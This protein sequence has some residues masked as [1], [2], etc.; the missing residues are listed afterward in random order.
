MSASMMPTSDDAGAGRSRVAR[1]AAA[2]DRGRN[3]NPVR[4]F[5]LIRNG[6]YLLED[7]TAPTYLETHPEWPA[8]AD[9]RRKPLPRQN[10]FHHAGKST[11]GR[12]RHLLRV[13]LPARN[14]MATDD[15]RAGHRAGR[16]H[17]NDRHRPYIRCRRHRGP[18]LDVLGSAE[19]RGV[20]T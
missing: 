10:R 16:N 13:I 15:Q 4:R 7:G 11:V 9:H 12:R 17:A 8:I 18:G 14:W 19:D 2:V 6:T 20:S 1:A 5:A 3:R